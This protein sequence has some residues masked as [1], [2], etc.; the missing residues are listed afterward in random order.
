MSDNITDPK[1]KKT[2]TR[3]FSTVIDNYEPAREWVH[4]KIET[5]EGTRDDGSERVTLVLDLTSPTPKP[6]L[7]DPHKANYIVDDGYTVRVW[8][9]SGYSPRKDRIFL[10]QFPVNHRWVESVDGGTGRWEPILRTDN[11][12]PV[13]FSLWMLGPRHTYHLKVK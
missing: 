3:D 1:M 2:W 10:E 9:V 7:K 11:Q 13:D 5:W 8:Y 6:A 12:R 4:G